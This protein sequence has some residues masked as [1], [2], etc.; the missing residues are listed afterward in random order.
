MVCLQAFMAK[1]RELATEQSDSQ[2]RGRKPDDPPSVYINADPRDS[3][4]ADEI[5]DAIREHRFDGFYMPSDVKS[6]GEIREQIR[7]WVMECDAIFLVY[8]AAD[9]DFVCS[10]LM[11][12]RKLRGERLKTSRPLKIYGVVMGP[13]DPKRKLPATFPEL[14]ELD[15]RRD[16]GT[17][18]KALQDLMH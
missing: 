3:K 7:Q 1:I 2:K 13:P 10:H 18:R 15:C 5:L 12:Y 16:M 14:K 8:G 6:S 17:I 9:F 11:E 4:L